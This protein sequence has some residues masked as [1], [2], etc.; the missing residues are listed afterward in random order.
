MIP[1]VKVTHCLIIKVTESGMVAS[2]NSVTEGGRGDTP[3]C[4]NVLLRAGTE[5]HTGIYRGDIDIY[6]YTG[7][8]FQVPRWTG[9]LLVLP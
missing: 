4:R 1:I 7:L 5:Q 2:E 3:A 9:L 8:R 6:P